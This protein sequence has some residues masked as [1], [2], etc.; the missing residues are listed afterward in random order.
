MVVGLVGPPGSQMASPFP[1]DSFASCLS[2]WLL[3]WCSFQ[4]RS[5]RMKGSGEGGELWR[6]GGDGSDGWWLSGPHMSPV[7]LHV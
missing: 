2:K 7:F 4:W 6:Y 1:G 5:D 3:L